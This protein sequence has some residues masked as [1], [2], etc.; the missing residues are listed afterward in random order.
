MYLQSRLRFTLVALRR[1]H[2]CQEQGLRVASE[3]I[4]E[5]V[6]EL[7]VSVGHVRFLPARR[8]GLEL[9]LVS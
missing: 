9:L 6:R 8:P 1:G 3:C 4:F 5:Q 7:G 2:A